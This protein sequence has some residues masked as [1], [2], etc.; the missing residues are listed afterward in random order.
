MRSGLLKFVYNACLEHCQFV[1]DQRLIILYDG[2]LLV[3]FA[4]E[5]FNQIY[6]ICCRLFQFLNL[7]RVNQ[8]LSV[9][10]IDP[11]HRF[12]GCDVQL[13]HLGNQVCINGI[14]YG[15]CGIVQKLGEL[16]V[17]ADL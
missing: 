15:L 12:L 2:N 10:G 14:L 9:Q 17:C 13:F 11:L 16:L 6:M 3:Y 1:N 5:R 7:L 8:G 4:I